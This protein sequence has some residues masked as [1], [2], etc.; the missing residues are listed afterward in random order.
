M[1]GGACRPAAGTPLAAQRSTV[2]LSTR[3]LRD[4]ANRAKVARNRAIRHSL[5]KNRARLSPIFIYGHAMTR[6]YAMDV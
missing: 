2:R 5:K 1:R 4:H 3:W 6:Q